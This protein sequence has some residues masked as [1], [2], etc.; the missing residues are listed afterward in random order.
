MDSLPDENRGP[1]VVA[2]IVV[3]T[4]ISTII[5]MLRVYSKIFLIRGMG[6]DDAMMVVGVVRT[7]A[8]MHLLNLLIWMHRF[9]H[10]Y[11]R[12][13]TFSISS[14]ALVDIIVS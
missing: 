9:F 2:L 8:T 3:M 5:V 14:M 1:G 7:T 11:T 13:L 10:S 6:W 4:V 12:P